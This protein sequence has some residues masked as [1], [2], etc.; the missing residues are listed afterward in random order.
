M[1]KQHLTLSD[2]DR[3]ELKTRLNKG[4][5]PAREYKRALGLLELD[6]GKTFTEISQTLGTASRTLRFWC[7]GYHREGLEM[8]KD[9]PRSGRPRVIDG[10]QRAKL[11]ALACSEPPEGHGRWTLRL[12]ADKAV[13]LGHCDHVSHTH[14]GRVLKKTRSNRTR[15]KPGV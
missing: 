14:A 2:S 4:Q 3:Q 1:Q 10:L 11:T 13:E 15:K 6:R 9:K 7:D 12:L 5:L 8:L